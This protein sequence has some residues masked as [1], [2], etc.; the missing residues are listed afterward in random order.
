[1]MRF[2][3]DQTVLLEPGDFYAFSCDIPH[4]YICMEGELS[5]TLI[6][7]YSH[8]GQTSP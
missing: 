4:S 1:M 3:E 7:S 8:I 6:M 5:G 2:N